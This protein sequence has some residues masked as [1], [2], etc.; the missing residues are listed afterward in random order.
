[1]TTS[2]LPGRRICRTMV[3]RLAP[4]LLTCVAAGCGN[5]LDGAAGG[6]NQKASDTTPRVETVAV[7]QRILEQTVEMPG[8]VEG[9]ETVDLYAKVGG[10]LEKYAKVKVEGFPEKTIELDIGDSIEAGQ[11]LAWLS[12]P[13]ME[14]QL[15]QKDALIIQADAEVVQ[16]SEAIR[17]ADAALESAAA[18]VQAA[19]A[20]GVEKVAQRDFR[21]TELKRLEALW[22][23]RSVRRELVVAADFQLK[24]AEAAIKTA[25]AHVTTAVKKK[26]AAEANVKKAQADEAA[27][28]AGVDV[29]HAN[30]DYVKEMMN[31][32]EIK[33]PPFQGQGQVIRRWQV[34]RRWFDP[35]AFVQSAAGNSAAK[36]LLTVTRTD[37]VRIIINIP[38]DKVRLLDKGDRAVLD[39][40]SVLPGAEPF[41]GVVSRF[42]AALNMKSRMMR[43]EVDL[44]NA[45]GQLRPGY[46]GL[47]T[48]YLNEQP[49]TL[50]IPSSALITEGSET[51]VYIALDGKAHKKTVTPIYQDGID[52][53]IESGD[54]KAGDQV[55]RS[56]GGQLENGQKII[57]VPAK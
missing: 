11:T 49:D 37:T 44:D 29:S 53:Y 30:R 19:E 22:E 31:Y 46:Y 38:M 56:G 32:R 52:V 9:Y 2:S 50:A 18:M 33:A 21:R 47:V 41:E 5:P 3:P 54:L 8:T 55:I 57:A 42:S 12:I 34:V 26:L 43:V 35:G 7:E 13:E 16:A 23:T 4:L 20:E 15:K 25:A 6:G 14:K 24:A 17:Q 27:A 39:D 28:I 10:F 36:P 40:I 51:F 1:M 48:L 45:D